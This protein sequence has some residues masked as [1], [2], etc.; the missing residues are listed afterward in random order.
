MAK[1]KSTETV[2]ADKS[3]RGFAGWD[4]EKLKKISSKG[5]KAAH[6]RGVAHEFTSEE[7]RRAGSLGGQASHAKKRAEAPA[8]KENAAE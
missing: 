1:T 2:I 3:K 6:D 7:A 5:G 8:A 4:P